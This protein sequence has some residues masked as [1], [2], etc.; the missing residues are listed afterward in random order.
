M[1]IKHL[2]HA[3]PRV[4]EQTVFQQTLTGLL[5]SEIE[6][7]Y[8]LIRLSTVGYIEWQSECSEFYQ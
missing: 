3:I 7:C 4:D 5:L 1:F 6:P 8:L 2:K